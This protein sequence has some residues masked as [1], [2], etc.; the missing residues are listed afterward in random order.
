MSNQNDAIIFFLN[1]F[2]VLV[3]ILAHHGCS[4]ITDYYRN[5][6][7][8]SKISRESFHLPCKTLSG[9]ILT[10]YTH[11]VLWNEL[12]CGRACCKPF[13][14]LIWIFSSS[15]WDGI[16]SSLSANAILLQ[17]SQSDSLAFRNHIKEQNS[18]TEKLSQNTGEI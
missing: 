4:V 6:N 11:R 13:F 14:L 8:H 16:I 7:I 5:A 3:Y 10:V 2:F 1:N 15:E 9:T 12:L 18:A 17:L